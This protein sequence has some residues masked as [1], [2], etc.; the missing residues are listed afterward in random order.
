MPSPPFEWIAGDP[1]LDFH[2]T[3]SWGRSG[4]T[5]ERLRSYADVV[6][7]G[8][9]AGLVAGPQALLARARKR[10]PEAAQALRRALGLRDV[11]HAVLTAIADGGAPA[12]AELRS[13][14]RSLS[15]ALRR[16]QVA[17]RPKGFAWN[18]TGTDA[19]DGVL[20]PIAWSAARLLTS[21]DSG[22]VGRCANEECGWLFVD[23]SRRRN[24]RWCEMSQCGSRAKARRYY[25]RQRARR[26]KPG[27]RMM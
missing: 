9:A 19:L 15:D 23:R 8:R 16:L 6:A 18:W 2:N 7:W 13:L 4:L 27:S 3:V 17:K 1:A 22:R 10:P 20:A 12:P 25:A 26:A 24:R 11:L 5:E 21:D 14:N